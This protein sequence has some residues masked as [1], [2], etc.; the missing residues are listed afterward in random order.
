ANVQLG[1]NHLQAFQ[2]V[3][4]FDVEAVHADF[5]GA[6]HVV[7]GLADAGE[8]DLVGAAASGQNAFQLTAGN[9]VETGAQT[10]QDIQYAQVGVGLYR[11]AHQAAHAGQRIGVSQVLS[12]DVRARVNVGRCTKAISDSRQGN[13]FREQFTVTVVKSVHDVPLLVD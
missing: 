10:R 5:Q 4:G 6:T 7:T 13:T 9:D 12:F 8:H 3:G 11:K 2:F 1:G